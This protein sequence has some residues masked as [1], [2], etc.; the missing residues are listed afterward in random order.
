MQRREFITLL[1]ATTAI[2]SVAA[3]AQQAGKVRRIGFL[4]TAS[5]PA[6]LELHAGFLQGMRDL[7]YFENKDFV[8]ELRSAE[9]QNERLPNLADE[10]VRLNVDVIVTAA[11]VAMRALQQATRTIPVVLAG[12]GDPVGNGFIASLARPGGNVTGLASNSY[13]T[14]S[15]RLEL[16]AMVVPNASRIGW[17]G[18]PENPTFSTFLRLAQAAA[19]QAGLTLVPIEARDL[20]ELRNAFATFGQERVAAVMVS[21]DPLYFAQRERLVEMAFAQR[22]PTSFPQ[23]EYAE[24][25]A[26]MSYGVRSK[27][28]YRQAAAYVD[29]IFKGAKP[30]DLPVELPTRFHLTINR[31]TADALGVTIPALLYI[32]ADEVI[33]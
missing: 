15:K 16:L 25:G 30:A 26:L 19:Q 11:A 20:P 13:D 31:K 32:F 7:G 29:K 4:T 14:T 27:V 8:S 9:G 17:L 18:N 33:D 10:L 3:R 23:H 5:R 12:T 21:G 28:L 22:L 1:G 24:A 2:A 6:F